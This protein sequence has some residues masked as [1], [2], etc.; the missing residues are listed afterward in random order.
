MFQSTL[1]KRTMSLVVLSLVAS[2]IIA[3]I[4]FV[5]AGKSATLTIEL[6]NA[7]KID[8]RLNDVFSNNP[9]YFEDSDFIYLFF[10]SS[11]AN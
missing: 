8:S 6:E 1:L 3:T 2:A 11:Y 7:L 10:G 4:A 9:E 5:V